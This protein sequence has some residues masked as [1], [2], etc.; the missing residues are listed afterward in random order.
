MK[1]LKTLCFILTLFLVLP[2]S[3]AFGASPYTVD[4]KTDPTA[5]RIGPDQDMVKVT[6]TAKDGQGDIVLGAYIK[7]DIHSPSRDALISTDFPWVE[8]TRLMAYEGYVPNGILA[9]DYIFPIRGKYRIE[10]RAGADPAS[11]SGQKTLHLSINENKVDVR[12]LSVFAALLLGFGALAGFIISRGAGMKIREAGIAAWAIL[13]TLG[14]MS[15][16]SHTYARHEHHHAM[17]AGEAPPLQDQASADGMT[18]NFKM[19]PGAGKVGMI[20]NLVFSVQDAGGRPVPNTVF[21]VVFRHMEDNKPVFSTRLFGQE[22]SADLGF[23]FFDGAEHEIKVTASNAMGKIQLTR[24]VDVQA[25]HPPMP[26]KIK[27]L[28]YSL[29]ITFLGILLGFSLRKAAHRQEN[30]LTPA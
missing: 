10:A 12:N 5:N 22:G 25:L 29:V 2:L 20:N 7:V 11:L 27:T 21:E 23:Q 14:F 8:S 30:I 9:F 3:P 18:L 4:L 28:F 24:S 6:L 15:C 19:D 26:V 1:N 17:D 16:P 13:L